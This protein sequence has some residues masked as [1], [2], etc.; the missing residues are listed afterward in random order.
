[1]TNWRETILEELAE[2]RIDP[3]T[4]YDR[5]RFECHSDCMGKCCNRADITLDPWDVENM[6]E[7]GHRL[8]SGDSTDSGEVCAIE[9]AQK[10]MLELMVG[11]L[12]DMDK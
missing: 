8:N 2:G 4:G 10:T 7:Q 5:F 1:M 12:K 9:Q 3:L 6:A 11:F